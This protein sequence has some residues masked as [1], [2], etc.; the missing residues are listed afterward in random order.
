MTW[1]N[2]DIENT[3]RA[4]T[5][6]SMTDAGF[7]ALALNN[8]V[9][10]IG[11]IATTPVPASFKIQFVDNA[12]C[13]MTVVLPDAVPQTGSINEDEL[14]AV[15]GGGYGPGLTFA[16]TTPNYPTLQCTRDNLTACNP[17]YTKKPGNAVFCP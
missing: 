5:E 12:N 6:R 2:Q 13:D 3:L 1:T 4:V 9:A 14:A 11:K 15:A 8:P 7:R 17:G 16:C 10:A